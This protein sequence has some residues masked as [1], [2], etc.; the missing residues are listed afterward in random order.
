MS[1]P[2]ESP[3]QIPPLSC[4]GLAVNLMNSTL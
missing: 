4:A 1:G 2:P 3:K